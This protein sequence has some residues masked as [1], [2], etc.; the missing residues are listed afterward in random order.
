ML[1][2]K[3]N[4]LAGLVKMGKLPLSKVPEEYRSLVEEKIKEQ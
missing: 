3:V 1:E 2:H 4:F